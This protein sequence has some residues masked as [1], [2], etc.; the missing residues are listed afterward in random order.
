MQCSVL[1]CPTFTTTPCDTEPFYG[2]HLWFVYVFDMNMISHTLYISMRSIISF[3]A[4]ISIYNVL[5]SKISID[6]FIHKVIDAH[7]FLEYH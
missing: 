4:L 1:C 6:K 2:Q 5:Y 3:Y 7:I